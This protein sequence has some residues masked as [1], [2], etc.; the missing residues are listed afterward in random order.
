MTEN[1]SCRA[2]KPANYYPARYASVDDMVAA[3]L[4]GRCT[5]MLGDYGVVSKALNSY[6][7]GTLTLT[8]REFMTRS[9]AF[10]VPR[11]WEHE[12]ALRAAMVDIQESH[13]LP[14]FQEFTRQFHTCAAEKP[15]RI[16]FS[17]LRT[18]FVLAFAACAALLA[19]MLLDPQQPLPE[20]EIEHGK[21]EEV[22]D[23]QT[24]VSLKDDT[25]ET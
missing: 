24:T 22:G 6:E 17:R 4:A 8:G 23:G 7:C 19:F 18:F 5:Y 25:D 16:T 9:V 12:P 21:P 15:P 20:H 2:N 13:E 1:R 3:L 11:N 14:S 10:I